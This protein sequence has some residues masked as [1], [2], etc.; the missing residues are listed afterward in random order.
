M[1]EDVARTALVQFCESVLNKYREAVAAGT[2][3]P[4]EKAV[5]RFKTKLYRVQREPF[6]DGPRKTR[7]QIEY[8][9][10]GA[11]KRPLT[12]EEEQEL[13]GIFSS[14]DYQKE[15]S[16][17]LARLNEEQVRQGQEIARGGRSRGIKQF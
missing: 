13:Q 4:Q 2:N 3:V 11:L 15:R 1:P 5:A 9:V 12:P 17:Y 10:Q 6:R 7:E 16:A 8:F 14:P